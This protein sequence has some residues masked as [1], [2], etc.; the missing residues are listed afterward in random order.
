MAEIDRRNLAQDAA[1]R[2]H[3]ANRVDLFTPIIKGWLTELA[4]ELTYLGIQIHG[5]MGFV[6]ETGAAQHYRDARILTIYEGTSGIQAM[7][8]AVRKTL[9]NG[10]EHLLAWLDEIDR[11]LQTVAAKQTLQPLAQAVQKALADA[12]R[13]RRWLLENAPKDPHAAGSAAFHLMM[14][15]GYLGGGWVIA[16]MALA[17]HDNLTR[18][19]GDT[20][21]LQAKLVSAQFYCAHLLPRTQSSLCAILAG[22]EPIMTLPQDQFGAA[23]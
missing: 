23:A 3:H 6:E 19:T 16:K 8:L 22:S 9:L 17:A 15:L 20:A 4:Q 12:H 1:A 7:D 10:G 11:D 18:Q 13:A 21:F 2:T 5:G 14:L